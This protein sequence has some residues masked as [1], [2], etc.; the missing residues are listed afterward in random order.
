LI[1]PEKIP[2][3]P[4]KN[5]VVT[6]LADKHSCALTLSS[7]DTNQ[8]TLTGCIAPKQTPLIMDVAIH[9][10]TKYA[11]ELTAKIFQKQNIR[12]SGKIIVGKKNDM[13][14][15]LVEHISKPLYQIIATMLKKSDNLIADAL[16]RKIGSVY[17]Q[18]QG[19]WKNGS[20]AVLEILHKNTGLDTDNL[21]LVDGAGISRYNTITPKQLAQV[22]YYDYHNFSI[23]PEIMIGLPI[24]GV[25]GTLHKHHYLNNPG[26][27]TVNPDIVGKLRAKTGTM[28]CVVALAG[29][30]QTKQGHMLSIVI[31]VNNFNGKLY[32]YRLLEAKIAEYLAN[33]T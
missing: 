22:L 8:Y 26:I 31:I 27:Y 14:Y 12:F 33:N 29:Y 3:F 5:D 21:T 20:A 11:T 15:L 16:I 19:N 23:A 13:R 18:Q 1:F 25:D 7:T 10:P 30:L 28:T 32:P 17:F 24:A 2:F 6:K 9:N 4:I